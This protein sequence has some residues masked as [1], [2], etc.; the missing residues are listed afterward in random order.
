MHR[1]HDLLRLL[2]L[3]LMVAADL[4]RPVRPEFRLP[5]RWHAVRQSR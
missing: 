5:Q 4:V 1:A 2:G 3:A